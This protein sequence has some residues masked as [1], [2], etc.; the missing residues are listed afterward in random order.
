MASAND[1]AENYVT[2]HCVVN[3]WTHGAACTHTT[4]LI[5]HTRPVAHKEAS[6][7][8]QAQDAN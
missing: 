4:T 8:L 2:I 7:L 3:N 5:S 6:I 1:T